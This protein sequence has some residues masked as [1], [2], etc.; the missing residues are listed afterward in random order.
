MSS[1][2][3]CN[4]GN[5]Y[6]SDKCSTCHKNISCQRCSKHPIIHLCKPHHT[7]RYKSMGVRLDISCISTTLL[8]INRTG[9]F[10]YLE[11]TNDIHLIVHKPL[12]KDNLYGYIPRILADDYY[13]AISL[14]N[15]EFVPYTFTHM[16]TIAGS[17]LSRLPKDIRNIIGDYCTQE[18]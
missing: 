18:N 15:D 2:K 13:A 9:T 7:M 11:I 8:E 1:L 6:F 3:C 14:P 5:I 16:S 12:F 4:F 17:Y 10:V